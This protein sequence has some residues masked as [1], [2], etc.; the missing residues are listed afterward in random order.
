LTSDP[1]VAT[2]YDNRIKTD[3]NSIRNALGQSEYKSRLAVVILSDPTT[4][5]IDSFQERLDS[6]RK[7]SGIDPKAFFLVPPQESR[8][9]LERIVENALTTIYVQAVEYYRDLGRHARKK[10]ARG[11][12]PQPADPPAP[13]T[14]QALS[15]S[16][17]NARYDFKSAIFAEYRQEMDN[18]L[19]SFEQAYENVLSS[20]VLEIIPSWSPRWNEARLLA[21]IIAIRCLRCLLWSGQYS[22]AVRR[23]Q[24]HRDRIG[25]LV[26]RRG[27]GTSNYGWKAWES[28]WATVMANLIER[29][30]VPEFA[31][32]TPTLFLQPEKGIM[33]ERLQPWELLH[34]T[35]YWYRLA[36][37]HLDSRRAY[38]HTIPENDR[39][40]PS[41][42]PASQVASRASTYDTFMCPDPHE[43]YP[44]NRVGVDH[45]RLIIKTLMKARAE[46]LKRQ[47]IRLYAEL[48]LECAKELTVLKDWANLVELLLPLWQDMSFRVEGWLDVCENLNWV[49]RAA[50]HFLGQADLIVAIDWELLNGSMFMLIKSYRSTDS[51]SLTLDRLHETPELAL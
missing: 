5:S 48:S 31:A 29:V 17:W 4:P 50:A 30:E 41:D 28:R 42:S 6:I 10:R 14:S 11:V 45:S 43:E 12:A 9:E 19:R 25:D 47:Q 34:H 49:L 51:P 36:A 13:G 1:T 37:R 16:A 46:F 38:A 32:S 7:G 27:R 33:G 23:W 24:T 15:V 2:L 26:D 22:A 40:S 18:A 8:E 35:G 3:I 20:E 21:D 44:L 39:R